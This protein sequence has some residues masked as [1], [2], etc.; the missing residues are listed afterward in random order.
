MVG[1]CSFGHEA[2]G[3]FFVDRIDPAVVRYLS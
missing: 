3:L 1:L 2:A